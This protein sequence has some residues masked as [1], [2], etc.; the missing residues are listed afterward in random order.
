MA[1]PRPTEITAAMT[2][3]AAE[4]VVSQLVALKLIAAEG[5]DARARDIVN[6]ALVTDDGYEIAKKLDARCSWKCNLQI[7]E[8]LD[9]FRYLVRDELHAAEALWA[10]ENCIE[11][12]YPVGSHVKL[13]TG[14][15]GEISDIS[16]HYAAKYLVAIDGDPQAQQPTNR[17][18]VV[19][20]E[21]VVIQEP[22][23]D[24]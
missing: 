13:R 10:S 8:E 23:R 6:C 15:K 5:V 7:A 19:N 22:E 2:L 3:A 11:P 9:A 14:E 24:S 16:S 20:F 1:K 18:Y 12:P 4:T 21:D 17:R